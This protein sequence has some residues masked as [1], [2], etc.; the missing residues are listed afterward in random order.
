MYTRC[1]GNTTGTKSCAT[2]GTILGSFFYGYI[3]SQVLGGYIATRIGG[4]HVFGVG[5]LMTS[6][7]TILTPF[8]AKSGVGV[9]SNFHCMSWG[10]MVCLKLAH[11]TV[12]FLRPCAS[13][14]LALSK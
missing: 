7:L 4:K 12:V 11:F 6:I 3:L 1:G 10:K 9:G 13:S 2:T 5:V 8:A 14:A